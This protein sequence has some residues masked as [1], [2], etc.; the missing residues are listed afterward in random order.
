MGGAFVVQLTAVESWHSVL[1]TGAGAASYDPDKKEVLSGLAWKVGWM[2]K[3]GSYMNPWSPRFAV[4][5]TYSIAFYKDPQNAQPSS[6]IALH[7]LSRAEK[8][9]SKVT[10]K[11]FCLCLQTKSDLE[12]FSL[13]MGQEMNETLGLTPEILLREHES[14]ENS[15]QALIKADQYS[16]FKKKQ[17]KKGY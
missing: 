4:L 12:H 6:Y 1:Y 17:P 8:I 5:R 3:Q 14:W 15:I 16:K 9:S 7:E 10:E 2:M 11:G 13:D